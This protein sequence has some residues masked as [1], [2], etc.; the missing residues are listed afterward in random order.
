MS[1]RFLI[2]CVAIIGLQSSSASAQ[3]L[4]KFID[5]VKYTNPHTVHTI[6]ELDYFPSITDSK[7]GMPVIRFDLNFV[8]EGDEREVGELYYH[9]VWG[10]AIGYGGHGIIAF[11]EFISAGVSYKPHEKLAASVT[12]EPIGIY[13]N[14]LRGVFGSG[15]TLQLAVPL[16]VIEVNERAQGMGHGFLTQREPNGRMRNIKLRVNVAPGTYLS[17]T[18]Q[19]IGITDGP[20]T[21]IAFGVGI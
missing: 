11:E 5:H 6:V 12:W 10:N 7:Y 8:E 17:I 20:L 2:L 15:L 3:I 21:S 18:R 16:A 19:A 9:G 13:V 14:P 1:R 4:E